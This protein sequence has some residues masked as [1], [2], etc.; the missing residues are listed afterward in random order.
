MSRTC[1]TAGSS[2]LASQRLASLDRLAP[3]ARGQGG[4]PSIRPVVC[5]AP[6]TVHRAR[7]TSS[8]ALA[9]PGP[10]TTDAGAAGFRT[11]AARAP[12]QMR[13]G[14]AVRGASWVGGLS[15]G[16]G[17]GNGCQTPR[18]GPGRWREAS[19]TLSHVQHMAVSDAGRSRNAAGR[20]VRS[21]SRFLA[22]TECR[23]APRS[24][25]APGCCDQLA[26]ASRHP[27]AHW[28][29]HVSG[30]APCGERT[31][32]STPRQREPRAT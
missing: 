22:G 21:G 17:H 9:A 13:T 12:A 31:S 27:P 19:P 3:P 4:A 23:E 11:T 1:H 15:T 10:R 20:S 30:M 25:R 18:S 29:C 28:S 32:V 2:H 26:P 24:S 14:Q 16:S 7:A 5:C 6:C 8:R